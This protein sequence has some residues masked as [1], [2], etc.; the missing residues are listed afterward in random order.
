[1]DG[2]IVLGYWGLRGN[3]QVARLLLHYTGAAWTEK[4]YTSP[5]EW[6]NKD[7]AALGF[8][9][10]NLPY[11]IQGEFKMTE[12]VAIH[13]YIIS[14]SN[15]KQLLGKDLKDQALVDNIEGV[16]LDMRSAL[17]GVTLSEN[18]STEFPKALQ[19][20]RRK[21]GFLQKYYEGKDF[22][23][24][25]LTLPDFELA[26]FAYYIRTGSK[27]TY[28]SFPFLERVRNAFEQL[29]EIQEYYTK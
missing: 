23:L 28:E 29:P 17:F 2:N 24:G 12:T 19:N 16:Y 9:F 20:I 25:Y 26:E 18:F 10:A 11:L 3:G 1:M 8:H 4:R 7:K 15:K 14:I 21:L 6:F 5:E 27:E 13:R 22:A